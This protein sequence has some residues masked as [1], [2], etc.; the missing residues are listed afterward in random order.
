MDNTIN[1]MLSMTKE[2]I[3]KSEFFTS[4]EYSEEVIESIVDSFN[5]D[6]LTSYVRSSIR[7]ELIKS[8]RAFRKACNSYEEV[9]G[10]SE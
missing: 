9:W 10:E 7:T 8:K 2:E 1:K 6:D 3:N 5:I 4:I